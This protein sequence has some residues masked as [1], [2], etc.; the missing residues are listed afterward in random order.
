MKWKLNFRA[1]R[2]NEQ[3]DYDFALSFVLITKLRQWMIHV[4]SVKIQFSLKKLQLL[5]KTK[6][7]HIPILSLKLKRHVQISDI[8]EIPE[9]EKLLTFVMSKFAMQESNK[10]LGKKISTETKNGGLA[11]LTN[12]L[13]LHSKCKISSL[14]FIGKMHYSIWKKPSL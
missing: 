8:F 11:F 13:L 10:K 3:F 12:F 14:K 1:L 7:P 5:G 2:S 6:L 9:N 4:N